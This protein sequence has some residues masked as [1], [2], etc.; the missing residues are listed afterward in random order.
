MTYDVD[1]IKNFSHI[2]SHKQ[3]SI[4]YVWF[5]TH[6]GWHYSACHTLSYAT[7]TEASS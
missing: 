7:F 6:R 4:N 3:V 2:Y 5:V 1:K